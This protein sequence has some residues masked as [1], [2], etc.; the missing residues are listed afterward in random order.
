MAHTGTTLPPDPFSS[1]FFFLSFFTFTLGTAASVQVLWQGM[2][3]STVK[4]QSVFL[5]NSAYLILQESHDNLLLLSRP[6][7]TAIFLDA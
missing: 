6:H 5:C 1:S 3:T 7:L 4:L 2:P